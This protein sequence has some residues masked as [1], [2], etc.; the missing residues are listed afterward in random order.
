MNIHR[1]FAN[2]SLNLFTNL[3]G[4]VANVKIKVR[5]A[6]ILELDLTVNKFWNTAP[7]LFSP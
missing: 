1:G 3:Q 7:R 4:C 5:L 6:V 2:F